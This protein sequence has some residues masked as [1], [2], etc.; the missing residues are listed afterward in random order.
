MASTGSPRVVRDRLW[1]TMAMAPMAAAR[2]TLG[3]GRAR[4]TNPASAASAS[5]GRSALGTPRIVHSPRTRPR[6]TATLAPLTADRWVSP[7]VSIASVRSGGVRLVSPMTRPGRRPRASAE[8]PSTASRSPARRR[9]AP[10]ATAPGGASVRG[11]SVTVT[12]ASSAA[13]G[14]PGPSRPAT[15]AVS[16]HLSEPRRSSPTRRT[17]AWAGPL[18]PRPVTDDA[19]APTVTR[20]LSL[21]DTDHDTGSPVTTTV[22]RALARPAASS[23]SSPAVRT[24]SCPA[25][26]PCSSARTES[27]STTWADPAARRAARDAARGGGRD[28]GRRRQAWRWEPRRPRRNQAVAV[29]QAVPARTVWAAGPQERVAASAAQ[30]SRVGT[31]SRRSPGAATG[32]G[33]TTSPWAGA[34]RGAS[35]RSR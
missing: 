5:T 10:R 32:R 22:S 28:P 24:S 30:P 1:P 18:R 7:V 19:R 34:G 4:T 16:P 11:L 17:G 3:S 2:T 23:S 6:T 8:V 13:P 35:R 25:T 14:S 33:L 29:A 15:S 31:R 27:P 9:S 26:A 21:S 12:T 20:R